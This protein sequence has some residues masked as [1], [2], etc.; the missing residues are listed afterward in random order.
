VQGVGKVVPALQSDLERE[1]CVERLY[2]NASIPRVNVIPSFV[3]I[4]KRECFACFF[5]KTH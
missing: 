3:R 5:E 4:V 1:A 2:A